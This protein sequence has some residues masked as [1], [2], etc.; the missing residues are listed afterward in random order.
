MLRAPATAPCD[1]RRLIVCTTLAALVFA[2]R[3]W[4]AQVWGSALPFWDEWDLEA[5]GLY[6][7][8]MDGTL[9]LGDLFHAHNEHR[10]LLTRLV[11]LGF[12]VLYGRW[13][14]LLYTSD[15]ADE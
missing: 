8:W 1:R 2:S 11:D 6:R 4:L 13:A 5:V 12:F 14:C 3:A 15:A 10:L 7:T 9:R